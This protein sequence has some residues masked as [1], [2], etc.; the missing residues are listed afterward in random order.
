MN[1]ENN[2]VIYFMLA[3]EILCSINMHISSDDVKIYIVFVFSG[4]QH[5]IRCFVIILKYSLN[6]YI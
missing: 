5:C 1:R 4:H 3:N 2:I 6:I